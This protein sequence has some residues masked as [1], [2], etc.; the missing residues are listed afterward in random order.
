MPVPAYTFITL[1]ITLEP[2]ATATRLT[3]LN[4]AGTFCGSFLD[5]RGDLRGIVGSPT[6][7]RV[8]PEARPQGVNNAGTVVGFLDD[9]QSFLLTPQGDVRPFTVPGATRTELAGISDAGV[10]VGT[11]RAADGSLNGFLWD[12]GH[13]TTLGLPTPFDVLVPQAVLRPG[14]VLGFFDLGGV[15]AGFL[16]ADGALTVLASPG[17]TATLAYGRTRQGLVVGQY[18]PDAPDAVL[19]SFVWDAGTFTA[20]AHP[21]ATSTQAR[22]V[23]DDGEVVGSWVDADGKVHGFIATPQG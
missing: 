12:H 16:L 10:L 22:G 17:A 18:L 5:A 2:G 23:N 3:G 4:T 9:G 13:L 11:Y 21:A 6:G 1:D 8:L 14:L 19:Q 7:L 15:R 20:L